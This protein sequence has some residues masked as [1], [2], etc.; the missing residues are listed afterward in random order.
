MRVLVTG[1]RGYIG[2][3]LTAV[4]RHGRHEVYGLDAGFYKGCEFG[5]TREEV[6]NFDVDVRDVEFADLLPFDAVVHL[7][8]VPSD[9]SIDADGALAKDV[10]ECGTVRLAECCRQAGVSRLV[11]VSTCDVYGRQYGTMDEADRPVPLTP[12]ASAKLVAER[13]IQQM[14]TDWFAPVV[15]RCP[16]VYGVSPGLH[17]DSL[18]NDFVA[19]A[20]T[21]GAVRLPGDGREWYAAVH[22]EDFARACVAV[23][24]SSSELVSRNIFNVVPSGPETRVID[25]ADTVVELVPESQRGPGL[26]RFDGPNCRIDGHRF[27]IAFPEFEFRWSLRAGIRQLRAAMMGTGMTP[28]DYRGDRFRRGSMLWTLMNRGDLDR[29]LRIVR[30]GSGVRAVASSRSKRSGLQRLPHRRSPETCVQT[31]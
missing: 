12:H 23:L 26:V 13:A 6:P 15:L 20:L 14:A 21:T 7:A 16:S 31:P 19:S 11:Y 18:T 5:R 4:L 25:I 2:S 29:S 22:V 8:D 1:H 24:A 3:V 27:T 28:S 9:S 30:R 10:I 17:L